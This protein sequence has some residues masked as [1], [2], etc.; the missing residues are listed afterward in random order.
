MC[1]ARS[2]SRRC[3][4]HKFLFSGLY[5]DDLYQMVF[6][7]PY[8][9]MSEFV[10]ARVEERGIDRATEAAALGSFH[11]F[12]NAAKFLWNRVDDRSIDNSYTKGAAAFVTLSRG[13]GHW[14][15]GRLSTY[16]KMLLLGLTVF[17]IVLIWGWYD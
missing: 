4:L 9:R 5:L 7:R 15:S 8:R 3:G 10:K 16:L 17:L 2:K 12:W 6:V 13:L 1:A 11:Q 14:T